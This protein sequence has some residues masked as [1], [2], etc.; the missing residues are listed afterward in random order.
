MVSHAHNHSTRETEAGGSG[1]QRPGVS[2]HPPRCCKSEA[3]LHETVSKQ[4]KGKKI[5]HEEYM[6][7]KHEDVEFHCQ[8]HKKAGWGSMGCNPSIREAE[9]G[10]ALGLIGQPASLDS[11]MNSRLDY[12]VDGWLLRNDT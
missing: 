2:G 10:E 1:I 3:E 12:K 4:Q 11:L 9:T 8:N 7:R 6:P 5:A